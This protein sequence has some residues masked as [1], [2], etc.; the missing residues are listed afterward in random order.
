LRGGIEAL[1]ARPV[2]YALA[3]LADEQQV[4]G[5]LQFGVWSAGSF[6]PLVMTGD[7]RVADIKSS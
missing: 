7:A 6:F 5:Q 3:E 4:D 2:Y 1:I